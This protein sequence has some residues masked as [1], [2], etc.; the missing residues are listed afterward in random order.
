ML[1]VPPVAITS[2]IAAVVAAVSF[3]GLPICQRLTPVVA[4]RIRPS[5]G[6]PTM[7]SCGPVVVTLPRLP[8]LS[9]GPGYLLGRRARC[10]H[11]LPTP[12]GGPH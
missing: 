9:S 5:R 8:I 1:R 10:Q 7:K 2:Q 6:R 11:P 12:G 4:L 3:E